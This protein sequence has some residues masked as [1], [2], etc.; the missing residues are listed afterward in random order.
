MFCVRCGKEGQVY[1]ALCVECFLENHRFTKLPGHV[2]LFRCA[3]CK[4]YLMGSKWVKFQTVEGAVRA[5][6]ER[7]LEVERGATVVGVK[8]HAVEADQVNY[9]VTIVAEIE[10]SDLKI[11]EE[12]KSIV[13]IKNS[14]CG[15]CSKIMGSYYES[16]VQIRGRER[17]LSAAQ[18]DR[19]L[20]ELA[21]LVEDAAKDN[22]EMFISKA[23][24]V[25]GG[26]D[27][28][29][30]SNSLGKS[31]SKDLAD[32]YGAEIKDSSTLVTQK[33]GKDLYRVTYLVRLPSYLRGEV[34]LYK[35]K[36]YLV[37][38]ISSNATKIIDLKTHEILNLPNAELREV[39]VVGHKEDIL[40]AVVLTD[41]PKEVQ[42][43]HPKTFRPLEVRKPHGYEHEGETV[44]I[45]LLED[46][47]YLVP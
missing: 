2:N 29:L 13:R 4:D 17:K 26:L 38:Q 10:Y 33:E 41:A 19:M 1:E 36:P 37:R 5:A 24:E 28:Y 6:A 43:L 32:H 27:I 15:R 25:A 18:K 23:E 45:F 14:V 3:H 39:K 16:I 34:I 20:D 30:S 35:S 46:D 11:T 47:V 40:E 8:L 42:I 44:R 21:D 7:A 31:V 9:H 12:S 22:R